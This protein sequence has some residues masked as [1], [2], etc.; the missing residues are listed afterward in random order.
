MATP[1]ARNRVTLTDELARLHC[2]LRASFPRVDR[3][4]VAMYDRHSDRLSTFVHSTDAAN[5]LA[6]Y[7]APCGDMPSLMALAQRR[8]SRTIDD[9]EGLGPVV[10]EHTK[11]LVDA[12]FRSSFTEPLFA[13]DDLL[14]FVFLDSREVGYFDEELR[15][16]LGLF[17]DAVGLLVRASMLQI[18]LLRSA[19]RMAA[20]L[21][22]ARDWETG[23]HLTRMSS[24]VRLIGRRLAPVLA[25]DDEFLE[26]LFLFAPL[27]DIGKVGV[28]DSVLLKPSALTALETIEMRAHV[29]TGARIV[30]SLMK[31]PRLAGL[32]HLEVLRDVVRHHHEAIDGSGY[33]DGLAGDRLPWASRIVSVADVFDALTTDRPYRAAWPVDRAFA[34]L[35]ERA[36]A[37]FDRLCVDAL[38]DTRLEVEDVMSRFAE[39]GPVAPAHD[40]EWDLPLE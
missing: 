15:E 5:P 36:G 34:F 37:V 35:R 12:G 33:P 3:A 10:R 32:P 20:D 13:G 18:E 11:R 25:F 39:T 30:E 22:R 26:F 16:R 2:R 24:Y 27:H 23:A 7:E 38:I 21:S 14:G 17:T 28:P 1:Q 29:I 31:D 9:L 19:V 40:H 6:T 8:V 4:A